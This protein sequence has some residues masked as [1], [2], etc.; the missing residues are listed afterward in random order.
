M[1][2][3]GD[4]QLYTLTSADRPYRTIVEEMGEGAATTTEAG[5]V[6]HVNRQLT[7][8]AG[9]PPGDLVGTAVDRLFVAEDGDR[10]RSLLEAGPGETTRAEL[11]LASATDTRVPVLVSVTG[12]DIEGV[13]VRC[14]VVS[15]LTDLH[16]ARQLLTD[17]VEKSA[18]QV[19]ELEQTNQR[20]NE[21]NAELAQFAYITS[22]DLSEPL[23]TISG[24]A[25]LLQ[26]RYADQLDAGAREMLDFISSGVTRMQ[27]L[28]DDLL[29]YSRLDTR[30]GPPVDV[31]SHEVVASVLA[32][33]HQRITEPR[34]TVRVDPLPVVRADR[35]QL[36]QVFANLIRNSLTFVAPG[37][38]PRIHIHAEPAGEHR[39]FT[40]ADNGI[41]IPDRFREQ[42]F[43]MF[44]RLHTREEYPGT[45]IG[46]CIVQKVVR[47]HGGQV[48][49]AESA[50]PGTQV[51]FTLPGPE[52]GR[53]D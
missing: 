14:L 44:K 22:H 26:H 46:L 34:A 5:T 12:L 38:D 17:A 24:F 10:L 6:L 41:G 52:G 3:P 42:V 40:V 28:I 9:S 16:H 50:E 8:L 11:T 53:R 27:Q 15:D 4:E 48:W 30:A 36:G 32:D 29:V 7:R 13:L 45:G 35:T 47:R 37:V 49:I 31:D 33:L 2:R 21:S 51:V 39:R 18:R 20:L 23:R 1:G 43:G 25:D 19:V